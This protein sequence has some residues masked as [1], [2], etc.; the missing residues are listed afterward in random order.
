MEQYINIA[1]ATRTTDRYPSP[2]MLVKYGTGL[3]ATAIKKAML[4]I[5]PA[6]L[7]PIPLWKRV[8]VEIGLH[9]LYVFDDLPDLESPDQLSGR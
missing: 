6:F 7:L 1:S 3:N 5:I 8:P 9:V 2:N 4:P